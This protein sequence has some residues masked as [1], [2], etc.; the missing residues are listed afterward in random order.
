MK[1]Y[2]DETPS[3]QHK[4]AVQPSPA[5]QRLVWAE[6]DLPE[7]TTRNVSEE[8]IKYLHGRGVDF[9]EY[10][11]DYGLVDWPVEKRLIIPYFNDLGDLIYLAANS[12]AGEIP[13]YMYP[14]GPK[15]LYMP[16]SR[17]S[18]MKV[19]ICEGQ[20]DSMRLV[21]AGY[22][23]VAIGGSHLAPHVEQ[24]LLDALEGREVTVCLDGDALVQ[25]SKLVTRLLELGVYAKMAILKPGQ[26]PASVGVERL[27]ELIG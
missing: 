7:G 18:A 17:N 1:L 19:V 5:G 2:G 3:P 12:Y 24:D 15:P 10:L 16:R 14:K 8:M 6:I 26:D 9:Y 4:E 11:A 23:G 13:K 22:F 21:D 25:A 20:F 27:K